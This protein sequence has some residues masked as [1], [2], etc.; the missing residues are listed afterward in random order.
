MTL[1]GA[2]DIIEFIRNFNEVLMGKKQ[3]EKAIYRLEDALTEPKQK[4]ASRAPTIASWF[5]SYL[6]TALGKNINNFINQ[7]LEIL[8]KQDFSVWDAQ[9]DLI[10]DDS[11]D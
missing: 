9:L 5:T 2:G 8:I 7:N 6:G 10:I 11:I 3:F 1:S 4:V